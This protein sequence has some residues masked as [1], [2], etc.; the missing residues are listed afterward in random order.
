MALSKTITTVHGFTAVNAYHRV[1][2]VSLVNKEQISFY[3]RSYVASD[4]PFFVE[5]VM[6]TSYAIDGLNPIAQAYNYVKTL[7]E[8]V[9]AVDC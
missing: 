1:E 9:G 4:K 7:P 5:Q 6:A 2:A 3:V 8:F